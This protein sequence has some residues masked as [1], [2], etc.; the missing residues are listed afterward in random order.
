[1][2]VLAR[3]SVAPFV[4]AAEPWAA[5]AAVEAATELKRLSGSRRRRRRGEFIWYP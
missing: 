3:G 2:Y 4:G 1:M 5:T